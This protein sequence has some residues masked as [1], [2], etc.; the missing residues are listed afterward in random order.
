MDQNVALL[1]MSAQRHTRD[2]AADVAT[3]GRAKS[4]RSVLRFFAEIPR[5][6]Q[7]GR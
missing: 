4:P 5:S 2:I 1:I 6:P 7:P 3:P